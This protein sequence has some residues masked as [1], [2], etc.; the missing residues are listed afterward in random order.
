[1][2]KIIEL[3]EW[4]E[5]MM[6]ALYFSYLEPMFEINVKMHKEKIFDWINYSFEPERARY[7]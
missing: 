3:K 1:M 4:N 6:S 2:S 5:E 7:H